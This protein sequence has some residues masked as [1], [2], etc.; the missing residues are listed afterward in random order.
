[1]RMFK[2]TKDF[3][4]AINKQH[5]VHSYAKGLASAYPLSSY[6]IRQSLF[7]CYTRVRIDAR[8]GEESKE[9]QKFSFIQQYT[10]VIKLNV[11]IL[12]SLLKSVVLF[13]LASCPNLEEKK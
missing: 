4:D 10:S 2:S 6:S 8:D 1:M 5:T 9:I 3:I 11:F 7:N 12:R 13:A